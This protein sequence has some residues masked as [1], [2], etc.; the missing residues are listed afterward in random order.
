MVIQFN[1]FGDIED[2]QAQV[3]EL[4]QDKLVYRIGMV[5]EMIIKQDT[6]LLMLKTVFMT[7]R[8]D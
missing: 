3:W 7:G 2:W 8:V 5:Q 6:Y 1:K 4:K